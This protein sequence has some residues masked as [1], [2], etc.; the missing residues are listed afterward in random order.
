MACL[1]EPFPA[2]KIKSDVLLI[3]TLA[4]LTCRDCKLLLFPGT[5]YLWRPS[6]EAQP[7]KQVKDIQGAAHTHHEDIQRTSRPGNAAR[8]QASEEL[9]WRCALNEAR[10]SAVISIDMFC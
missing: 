4:M 2:K 6:V 5:N 3:A 7:V 8:P 1:E 10:Y 9:R